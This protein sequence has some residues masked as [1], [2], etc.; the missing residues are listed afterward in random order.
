MPPCGAIKVH[1]KN[2]LTSPAAPEPMIHAGITCKGSAAAYGI[3]PSV[4][5]ASHII[6]LVGPASLSSLVNLF[7]KSIVARAIAHG[8]TIP[9]I[10]TAAIIS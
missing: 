9:P 3:A 1:L 4:I 8:G 2:I 6:K 7:L 5:N 10:I